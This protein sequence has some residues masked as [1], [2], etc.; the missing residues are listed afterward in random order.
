[1][2][3]MIEVNH[4]E[5]ME[6]NGCTWRRRFQRNWDTMFC[7]KIL[8]NK[9]YYQIGQ[10]QSQFSELKLFTV[11]VFQG[12][13]KGNILKGIL[14]KNND[15]SSSLGHGVKI[16]HSVFPSVSDY[17]SFTEKCWN[18]SFYI[19]GKKKNYKWVLKL[20]S[21]SG[22]SI[23][24]FEV[25]A[26]CSSKGRE[27]VITLG[28]KLRKPFEFQHRIFCH[29]FT[30]FWRNNF[31]LATKYFLNLNALTTQ[32]Y[33]SQGKSRKIRSLLS[34]SRLSVSTWY[35]VQLPS[36]QHLIDF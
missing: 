31:L 34:S 8:E 13:E 22:T 33:Y 4:R 20:S 29:I 14:S 24:F 6:R 28:K 27:V 35:S 23:Y 32:G 16:V 30:R 12:I 26:L 18:V 10:W 11:M 36:R 15:Y 9:L 19:L 7:L 25:A 17:S 21:V 5:R 2:G 3:R 1:M